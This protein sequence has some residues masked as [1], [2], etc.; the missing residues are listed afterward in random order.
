[1]STYLIDVDN[2]M[3]TRVNFSLSRKRLC[4]IIGDSITQGII[5]SQKIEGESTE[6]VEII[7]PTNLPERLL[8]TSRVLT[9]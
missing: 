8:G 7:E 2:G 4:Q 9:P 1:M 3:G 6:G 5:A